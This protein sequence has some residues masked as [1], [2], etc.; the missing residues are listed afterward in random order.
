MFL[1]APEVAAIGILT[2]AEN[3]LSN[4]GYMHQILYHYSLPLVP[5][6]ALGTVF[7]VVPL[8]TRAR[9]YVAT[10]VVV[11]AAF[12]SCRLWGLAP[13]SRQAYPHANPSS[14]QVHAINAVLRWFRPTRSSPPTTP[15]WPTWTTAPGSTSGPPRS[16]PS[17]GAL[18][19]QEGQRLPFANQVQYVVIPVAAD[20]SPPDLAVWASISKAVPTGRSGWR[21]GGV[22][23]GWW[24]VGSRRRRVAGPRRCADGSLVR[25]RR[26][27]NGAGR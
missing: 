14:P 20:L 16:P 21:G 3:V 17:T 5:V 19:T 11:V 1:I 9:R 12:V 4:F 27:H 7:A 26:G 13:F 18:Y 24:D 2:L 10:G 25:P 6:L 15:T 8:S 23:P 22:P